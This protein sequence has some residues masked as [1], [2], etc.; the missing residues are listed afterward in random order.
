MCVCMLTWHMWRSE[1]CLQESVL[2]STLWV[3]GFNL[4]PSGLVVST[5]PTEPL[6]WA[7][8]EVSYNLWGGGDSIV[9]FLSVSFVDDSAV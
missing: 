2:S 4:V 8:Y 7:Q 9:W 6:H 5:F 3:P 1:A